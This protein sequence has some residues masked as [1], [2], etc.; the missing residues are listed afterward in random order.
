MK[1]LL[2]YRHILLKDF[3]NFILGISNKLIFL[4]DMP[5]MKLLTSSDC[6]FGSRKVLALLN[7]FI[8]HIEKLFIDFAR[9][10]SENDLVSVVN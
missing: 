4:W 2:D 7:Y 3:F 5:Q 8:Y 9:R 10:I 6:V 1:S